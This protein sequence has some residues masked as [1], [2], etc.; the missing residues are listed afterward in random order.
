[1]AIVDDARL[2]LTDDPLGNLDL[3]D[4]VNHVKDDEGYTLAGDSFDSM[5][6]KTRYQTTLPLFVT[7][8]R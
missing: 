7:Y 6:Q 2:A 3:P 8:V 4:Y 1:M 5:S